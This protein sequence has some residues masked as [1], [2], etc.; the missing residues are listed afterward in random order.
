[1]ASLTKTEGKTGVLSYGLYKM[2]KNR[3]KYKPK[4]IDGEKKII[5]FDQYE[6]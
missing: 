2:Y 3:F 1:M 6:T 4:I 5:G